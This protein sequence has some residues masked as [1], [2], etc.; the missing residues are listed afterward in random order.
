[1]N[2]S[3]EIALPTRRLKMDSIWRKQL[4]PVGLRKHAS[5]C[6]LVFLPDRK[7]RDLVGFKAL[8][9]YH[10]RGSDCLCSDLAAKFFLH[11]VL[12]LCCPT[13]THLSCATRAKHRT[14]KERPYAV[15]CRVGYNSKVVASTVWG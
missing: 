8:A 4:D 6:P 9:T 1:M 10:L 12:R 11:S 14:D 3:A 5:T 15:R 2:S 13:E 7:R